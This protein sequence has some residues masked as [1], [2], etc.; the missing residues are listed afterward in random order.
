MPEQDNN[1]KI[2]ELIEIIRKDNEIL[3][4]YE[5]WL[6]LKDVAGGVY[7]FLNDNDFKRVAVYGMGSLGRSVCSELMCHNIE[8]AYVIEQNPNRRNGDYIFYTM[9]DDLPS[10]DVIIVT[11]I[12][13]YDEIAEELA[14]KVNC[15]ILS[16]DDVIP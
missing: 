16:L 6:L 11:P 4:L 13:H 10:I 12:T 8:V 7:K 9:Q 14:K 3:K 5:R 1:N 15:T 2:N